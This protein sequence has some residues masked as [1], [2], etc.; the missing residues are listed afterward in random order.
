MPLR[1]LDP[2]AHR[3]NRRSD[4]A[5]LLPVVGKVILGRPGLAAVSGLL[6]ELT[7]MIGIELEK[8]EM[9]L[10]GCS[11]CLAA[12]GKK[13]HH[14]VIEMAFKVDSIGLVVNPVL[15][16]LFRCCV[17][18]IEALTGSPGSAGPVFQKHALIDDELN[19]AGS[20]RVV[21]L[22]SDHVPFADPEVELPVL[23]LMRA[24][25]SDSIGLFDHLS[26]SRI[27]AQ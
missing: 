18:V 13:T 17:V 27:I 11:V 7:D 14:T 22:R 4:R 2:R 26:K 15:D 10:D 9:A 16:P 12:V 24:G 1:P 5:S 20:G 25:A 3:R 23:R 21:A 19:A 8:L 6:A